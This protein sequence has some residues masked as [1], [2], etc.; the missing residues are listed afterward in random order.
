MKRTALVLAVGLAFVPGAVGETSA[1]L[2]GQTSWRVALVDGA[3]Q[4]EGKAVAVFVPLDDAAAPTEDRGFTLVGRDVSL[5]ELYRDYAGTPAALVSPETTPQER[6]DRLSGGALELLEMRAQA[7]LLVIPPADGDSFIADGASQDA[8]LDTPPYTA[9]R[10]FES[11]PASRPP[12]E[13][14]VSFENPDPALLLQT[15]SNHQPTRISGDFTVILWDIDL[16]ASDDGTRYQSGTLREPGPGATTLTPNGAVYSA[17]HQLLRIDVREGTLTFTMPGHGARYY[18][19][20]AAHQL[21]T[22]GSM[23]LPRTSGSISWDGASQN[24]VQEHL[25]IEGQFTAVGLGAQED[26]ALVSMWGGE[27]SAVAASSAPLALPGALEGPAF[28]FPWGLFALGISVV[29]LGGAS[30][31]G[32]PTRPHRAA[33]SGRP[34]LATESLATLG[35]GESVITRAIEELNA[36][37][38]GHVLRSLQPSFDQA[39]PLA[40]VKAYLIGLACLKLERLD[41]AAEWAVVATRLYPEFLDQLRYNPAFGPIREHPLVQREL[42]QVW[43]TDAYA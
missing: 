22:D 31:I 39:E 7:Q 30:V 3:L 1:P 19:H 11:P 36:E 34:S 32:F 33:T 20:P 28:G 12:P 37:R 24:L 15:R 5:T 13:L 35:A 41:E 16:H 17:R 14:D 23:D 6:E 29:G 21:T 9:V 26:G 8:F 4:W 25:R 43:G 18:L 42:D 10:F 38:P 40:P 27:A 2:S